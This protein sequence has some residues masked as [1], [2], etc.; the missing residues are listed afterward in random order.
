MSNKLIAKMLIRGSLAI[1]LAFVVWAF[2]AILSPCDKGIVYAAGEYRLPWP[3]CSTVTVTQGNRTQGPSHLPGTYM[4][5]AI[6]FGLKEGDPVAA[7]HEGKVS[8]LQNGMTACGGRELASKANYVVIDHGDD[9]SAL[10]LHLQSASVKEGDA[11][12]RG[13]I[14]GL[15]GK[16]GWTYCRTH[17]H[18]QL[19]KTGGWWEQSRPISFFEAS[20]DSLSRGT[21]IH[22]QN[23]LVK[24]GPPSTG[25][26]AFLNKNNLWIGHPDGSELTSTTN[27]PISDSQSPP[28]LD[29][30]WSP[31]GKTLAY[32][33]HSNIYLY[34][35]QTS[36]TTLLEIGGSSG[37]DWGG[38]DWSPNGNQIIYA[39]LFSEGC[40]WCND[41]L[42]VIRIE[43]GRKRQVVPPSTNIPGFKSPQWS[44][45]GS[46]VLFYIPTIF[47]PFSTPSGNGV[48]DFNTGESIRL[49]I[50]IPEGQTFRSCTWAPS[51]LT[52]AC[53]IG[54][55]ENSKQSELLLIDVSG[56]IIRKIILPVKMQF[57]MVKWSPDG[58]KLAI[59]YYYEEK[60]WTDILTLDTQAIETLTPGLPSDWSPDGQWLLITNFGDN[61]TST[62]SLIDINTG[63][64]SLLS[65]GGGG[66]WQPTSTANT[67]LPTPTNQPALALS[68]DRKSVESVM[69]WI[70]YG[71]ANGDVTVFEELITEDYIYYGHGM[72]GGR[73]QM[74]RA[75]FF[76]MLTERILSRPICEGYILS[77]TSISVFTSS[78]EPH[79]QD[80]RV[81]SEFIN[82]TLP[83][84]GE[85][86]SLNQAFFQPSPALLEYVDSKP[87][88]RVL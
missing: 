2:T 22:S 43:D 28:I 61:G 65:E 58:Q 12:A 1:V 18:F 63:Q 26:I 39:T 49:P 27:N 62:I 60:P 34:D 15:A 29:Y 56:N 4:E 79:W 85:G 6:D 23:S 51:E 48:A 9:T 33:T 82:F 87:C 50:N 47:V 42:W 21:Q 55:N 57:P 72:A 53:P 38:F 37:F 67:A 14:I 64:A 5:Y 10:Y 59:G 69:E 8:H 44:S 46:H 30:K 52:I 83:N 3:I 70:S 88:P 71:L 25:W 16:T 41:G 35:T 77:D 13:Q 75:D 24:S 81:S 45:E 66:V 76:G 54:S 86:F 78:W 84:F 74:T 19:Q 36:T 17:L 31:D 40:P 32:S 7:V 11:V 80:G 68:L 20:G 73:N